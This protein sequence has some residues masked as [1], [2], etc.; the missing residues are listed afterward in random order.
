MN[1]FAKGSTRQ[2]GIRIHVIDSLI[3]YHCATALQIVW[4][5]HVLHDAAKLHHWKKL[6]GIFNARHV[7]DFK[8]TFTEI[9]ALWSACP[10]ML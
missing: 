5:S 4:E 6:G 9:M 2:P 7:E 8:E 10:I 1:K 3:L